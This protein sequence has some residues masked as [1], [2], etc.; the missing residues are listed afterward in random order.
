[1]LAANKFQQ[2]SLNFEGMKTVSVF[3]QFILGL[4]HYARAFSFIRQNGLRHWYGIALVGTLAIM[5]GVREV[6]SVGSERASAW[7]MQAIQTAWGNEP[8]EWIV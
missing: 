1:M 8:P 5:L 2:A 4:R 3:R 6:F 7:L